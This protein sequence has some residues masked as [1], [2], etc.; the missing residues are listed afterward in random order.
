MLGEQG[1][2]LRD[3]GGDL[4]LR[5]SDGVVAYQLA[6]AADD[7]AMGITEVVRGDDLLPSTPRQLLLFRLMGE[8]PPSYAHLPLLHD[9]RGARLAKRHKSLELAAL[10]SAGIAPATI[11]GFLAFLAGW[12]DKPE[13]AGPGDL[14]PHFSWKR[15]RG[16]FLQLPEDPLAV[17][18]RM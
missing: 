2:R 12:L 4:A 9:A 8:S 3:C 17:L 7:A 1:R 11:T 5:R 15:L 16:R 18:E 13:A 6:V 10:R 14:L